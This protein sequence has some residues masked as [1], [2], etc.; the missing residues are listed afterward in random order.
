V[1]ELETERIAA[2]RCFLAFKKC[3]GPMEQFLYYLSGVSGPGKLREYIEKEIIK[4]TSDGFF[5]C[6]DNIDVGR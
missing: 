6:G 5:I 4:Q 1:N 2:I 3:I